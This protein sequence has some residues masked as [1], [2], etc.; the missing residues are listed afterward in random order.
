MEI[1]VFLIIDLPKY[2]FLHQT[3]DNPSFD[4]YDGEIPFSRPKM[5]TRFSPLFGLRFEKINFSGDF[6]ILM[7]KSEVG[8]SVLLIIDLPKYHF[9]YQTEDNP[10]FDYFDVLVS[11]IL[12]LKF[13]QT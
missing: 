1:S 13:F 4:Y 12:W 8:I 6:G 5:T 11:D 7:K 10:S 3:E 2:H 9:L